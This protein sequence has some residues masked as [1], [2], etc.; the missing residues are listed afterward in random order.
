MASNTTMIH[1]LQQAL[2][3]HGDRIMYSTSQFYSEQQNRP[4]TVYHV[5]RAV[6]DEDKGKFMN[7][8]LFKSTSQIQIVLFLRDMWLELNGKPIP[9][10][11][12]V[13]NE[14]KAQMGR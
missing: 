2:N 9:D 12:E 1:K 6:W 14:K 3:M 7:T 5:K 4:V 13:W 11:N 8:E 10:N